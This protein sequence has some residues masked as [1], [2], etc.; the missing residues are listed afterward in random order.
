MHTNSKFSATN[1]RGILIPRVE[2][3]NLDYI[4]IIAEPIFRANIKG[5]KGENGENEYTALPPF[6]IVDLE[7]PIPIDKQGNYDIYTQNDIVEK[8]S[9]INEIKEKVNKYRVEIKNTNVDISYDSIKY[10]EI[11]LNDIF[12]FQRGIVISKKDIQNCQGEY[13]VYSSNTLNGGILG[14][15]DFYNYDIEGLTWT[16][17]GIHAGTIFY[18]NGKFSITN[19]CGLMTLKTEYKDKNIYLPYIKELLDFK[20]FAQCEGNKKVMTNVIMKQNIKVKIPVDKNNNFDY[21][22]QVEIADKYKKIE[23][24]K[25]N[26]TQELNKILHIKIAYD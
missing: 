8:Y 6:M 22:K 24:I 10:K 14:Y 15:V 17:D 26:I 11:F 19:V 5:R 13:P 1:H 23:L 7:I 2:N 20:S 12:D 21:Q 4:K 16:T 9:F 3:L 25:D 18:R